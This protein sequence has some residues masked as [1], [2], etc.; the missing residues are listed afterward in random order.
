MGKKIRYA[1]V[2]G[3]I[4]QSCVLAEIVTDGLIIHL[5]ADA[6]TGLTDGDGVTAWN[7]SAT[8]DTVDG[9]VYQV[10]GLGVPVYKTNILGGRPVVRF[11]K[12]T[13]TAL[14]SGNWNWTSA[15][16]LTVLAVFTGGSD[17]ANGVAQRLWQA[18]NAG[19]TAGQYLTADVTAIQTTQTAGVRY[20][21]GNA[22]VSNANNPLSAGVFKIS[23]WQM[24][25][26]GQYNSVKWYV[27]GE[28]VVFDTFS[29]PTSVINLIDS[30]N[31]L[32]VGCGKQ[33]TGWVTADFYNGDIE[34]VLVYNTLLTVSQISQMETYLGDK[35]GLSSN[36]ARIT[37][38]QG[39][40]GKT[41]VK[42]GG[43]TD[44]LIF[45]M[46]SDP[47]SYPVTLNIS[48]QLD[49][50]QVT[51]TPSELVFTS[52]DWQVP[53]VVS[54]TAIDDDRMERL[55]HSTALTFTLPTNPASVYS[56]YALSDI[57][58]T[59]EDN[60][61]GAWGFNLADY[62]LDCQ[63]NLEDFNYFAQ[64]WIQCSMPDPDCQDY[65]P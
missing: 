17:P 44:D 28:G 58:V 30:G 22:M 64:E 12:A 59:I 6:L 35:Y 13:Q 23:T 41:A 1:M 14:A 33:T 8:S 48:D 36:G 65:R 50:N 51:L 47:G 19:G 10:S 53:R 40:D 63:V 55:M 27:D 20:G 7:D 43:Y 3:V 21:N 37:I 15:N 31:H 5:K 45:T 2:L 42:E 25:D 9:T 18:G 62:N 52:S 61:C 26:G 29:N 11:T 60:D 56:V 38:D 39:S 57:A 46:R 32:T 24:A 34:E 16:G 54:L 49:P 4:L